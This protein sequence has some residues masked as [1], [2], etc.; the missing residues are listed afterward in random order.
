MYTQAN[1]VTQRDK[2]NRR[3]NSGVLATF[4]VLGMMGSSGC[5]FK[6]QPLV[7]TPPPP[8]AQPKVAETPTL[9]DPPLIAGD[10]EA[11][12]P[13]T[14]NS[15]PEAPAPPK[16]VPQPKKERVATTPPRPAATPAPDQ[17]EPPSLAPIFTQEERREY[18]KS[19]DD[20]LEHVRR[21]LAALSKKNL[22]PDQQKEV[23][24]ISTFQKQAEQMREAQD[25]TT[26]AN[27]AKRAEVLA[28]DLLSRFP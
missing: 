4:V 9:A 20:S 25:L 26:A 22:N 12:L 24:L 16:P 21:D 19:I 5:F 13:E 17:P 1:M 14:P 6:K 23:N 8:Q 18:N 7:F 3:T 28:A 11:A 27:I 2:V 15:I 10:P